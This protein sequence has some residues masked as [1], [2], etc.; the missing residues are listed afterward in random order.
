M[1]FIIKS[2]LSFGSIAKPTCGYTQLK[3]TGTF[4]MFCFN[5]MAN[6]EE[7]F[8]PLESEDEEIAC[9]LVDRLSKNTKWTT[10]N[11]LKSI[12]RCSWGC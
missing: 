8:L 11:T 1:R 3:K 5:N 4:Q 6:Q 12:V 2:V 7:N 10:E 9:I